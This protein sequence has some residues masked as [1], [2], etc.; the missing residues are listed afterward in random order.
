VNERYP[1]ALPLELRKVQDT[2]IMMEILLKKANSLLA[3]A[4]LRNAYRNHLNLRDDAL[5]FEL[6]DWMLELNN[7]HPIPMTR[8]WSCL[9]GCFMRVLDTVV[10]HEGEIAQW[11]YTDQKKGQITQRKA[12]FK[13]SEVLK[14]FKGTSGGAEGSTPGEAS[15]VSS[16]VRQA[17]PNRGPMGPV[18]EQPWSTK[19]T[20]FALDG[21]DPLCVMIQDEVGPAVI[22]RLRYK[23]LDLETI[24]MKTEMGDHTGGLWSYSDITTN[25]RYR[26]RRALLT[27]TPT[28]SVRGGVAWQCVDGN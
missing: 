26:H 2:Y 20:R 25:P 11:W 19:E 14:H 18:E 6:D 4:S 28:I 9:K 15:Y 21:K 10:M 7:V 5:D 8:T 27:P 1:S 22:Y 23:L 13:P 16:G 17:E 24:E 12:P 3:G